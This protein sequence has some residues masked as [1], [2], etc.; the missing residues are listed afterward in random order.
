MGNSP[1]ISVIIACYND[2]IYIQK[3]IDSVR[4][5]S[6]FNIELIIVDDGS[7]IAT[8][9]KLGALG[10]SIDHLITQENLGVSHARNKGILA[11]NGAYIFILDSDD[12]IDTDYLEVALERI[13]SDSEIKIVSCH[14]QK[15]INTTFLDV[16]KP[17][18]GTAKDFLLTNC[19]L[20]GSMYRKMD[21]IDIGGYDEKMVNGYE[22][23][24]LNLNILA[25][26]GYAFIIE[27]PKY[28]YRSK[29]SSRNSMAQINHFD[30][31][32]YIYQKHIDLVKAHLPMVLERLFFKLNKESRQKELLRTS[33]EYRLASAFLSPLRYLKRKF[34]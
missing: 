27:E 21:L 8:K 22:D 16:L 33:K 7:N 23:W 15:F 32:Y 13:L 6:Y 26:G 24:E 10:K 14:A 29:T 9:K 18:G 1:L 12:Y 31:M 2:A 5:Q 34:N 4:N 11:A 3:A 28:Y 20:G 19:A 17:T 30:L 25:K